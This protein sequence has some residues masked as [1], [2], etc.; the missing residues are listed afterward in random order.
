MIDER[1]KEALESKYAIDR[2]IGSG[3]MATVYLARDLKHDREVALKVLRPDLSAV[4][5]TE[6]FLSE[7]RITAKLD[8]PHILTLIDSGEANGI[9]YYVLPYVRGESLRARLEREKQLGIDDATSITRQVASA[10][11]YA[12]SHGVVHRD[13]KPENILLHEGEAVLA[14]F[15]IAL[16]V[17]EAGGNRLTETGLSLGTPQYMSPEQAT[18][19]RAL[20]KRSDIYSLGAVFYEMLAGEPPVTG[21]TAQAMIAKLMTE[22]PVKLRV[23]RNTVPL[24]VELAAEKA[25]AKV[26]ADRYSS[27]GEFARAV[28]E[29]AAVTENET[30][31]S[32]KPVWIAA[33]AALVGVIAL[34]AFLLQRKDNAA[35]RVTLGERVQLTNDGNA[36]MG[37]ISKDGKVFVYRVTVCGTSGCHYALDMRD[38]GG[39]VSR[40]VLDNASA[41]YRVGISPDRR[42]II[43]LGSINGAFG[44]WLVSLVGGPPKFISPSFANFYADG[45]S[46][47]L[48]RVIRPSTSSW[49]IFAGLDGVPVDSVRVETPSDR[50]L[51]PYAIPESRR[52]AVSS[53]SGDRLRVDLLERDGKKISSVTGPVGFDGGATVSNDAVWF[54]LIPPVTGN[55]RIVRVPF[56]SRTMEL[57][58]RGD[59]VLSGGT[60]SLSVTA[61]GS[62]MIYDE[63]ITDESAWL[64]PFADV[65]ANNFD[66]KNRLTR[67]T[68]G[69]RGSISA[70]GGIAVIGRSHPQ[71]GR[72]FTVIDTKTRAEVPVPGRHKSAVPFDSTWL[73]ITDV[74]ETSTTMYLYDYKRR[75]RTAERTVQTTGLIDLTRVGN[76]WA[77]LPPDRNHIVIQG[78]GDAR[79]RTAKIPAWFKSV[80]WIHGSPDGN[81]LALIGYSQPDED[82]LGVG[83]VTLPDFRFTQAH[84]TFGEGGGTSWANDG[85]L[86][87]S[88][89]DTP[90]S[91][92]LWQWREGQPARKLGSIQRLLSNNV[93]ATVSGDLKQVFM[94]TRDDRRDIWIGK[95]VR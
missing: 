47:M 88:I 51:F 10:L 74:D 82:S 38:V 22:R 63:G 71:G 59:T 75:K 56:D 24:K 13:I 30:R 39:T 89:N 20:D 64:V 45:D 6:R 54:Y 16:A 42:N 25:L 60:S 67:T 32:R 72:E 62:T 4:I 93:T 73:K 78:D 83:V 95:V 52:F 11:D 81:K 34:V 80:F 68:S 23:I 3:G 44:S 87:M 12:H 18:G 40:R 31:G 33:A 66:E 7:V 19:D 9:L 5:G 50:S 58:S 14:D 94:I 8:H 43:M 48:T 1:L 26:P 27:A 79:P 15:G 91:E 70:D 90:E 53:F 69:V 92:S 57:A 17:K 55:I 76:S 86:V 36:S 65:V 85:S 49:I 46:V 41:I 37:S 21:G 77:W 35:N 84:V 2:E 61:D 28:S 29:G